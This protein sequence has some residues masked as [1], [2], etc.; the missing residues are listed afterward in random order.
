MASPQNHELGKSTTN[1]VKPSD[2][3][4]FSRPRELQWLASR[5]TSGPALVDTG[6]SICCAWFV[7]Q[8]NPPH[9]GTQQQEKLGNQ[10]MICL[11]GSLHQTEKTSICQARIG[12]RLCS[13][14]SMSNQVG[15]AVFAISQY[16]KCLQ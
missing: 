12:S 1:C 4:P 8:S 16:G 7:R 9:F 15:D 10:R 13:A 3:Y 2:D 11:L 6:A 14:R 5:D